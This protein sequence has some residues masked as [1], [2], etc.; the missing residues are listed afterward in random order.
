EVVER[1]VAFDHFGHIVRDGK[2]AGGVH[3]PVEMGGIRRQH[4]LAAPGLHAYALQALGV[5][6][7]MVD[8]DPWHDL[9]LTVVEVDA[10]GKD[11]AHHRDHVVDL[12]RHAQRRVA[13]AAPRGIG[14]LAILQ[15]V[16]RAGKQ[17][18]VANVIVMHVADDDGP[19]LRGVDAD[20]FQSLA[21]WLDHFALALLAH[22]RVEAGIEDDGAGASDNGPNVEIERLQ[23][24]V[25][26][27]AD[28]VFR[29]LAIMMLVANGI[30]FV[31]VVAHWSSPSGMRAARG[32]GA[33]RGAPRRGHGGVTSAVGFRRA[34][35]ALPRRRGARPAAPRW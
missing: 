15:V 10:A 3:M 4:D 24:V 23:H 22:G 28:E 13:H 25:G 6:A 19:Y 12:E 35:R 5:A 8:G 16:A 17:V 1:V 32:Q 14:H 21:D 26:V 29:C 9:V 27:A 30:D 7:D 31:D 34:A 33:R 11:L 2:Y 18:V 20:R